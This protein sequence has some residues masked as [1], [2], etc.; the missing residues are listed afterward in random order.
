MIISVTAAANQYEGDVFAV[1][2]LGVELVQCADLE[3]LVFFRAILA[4]GHNSANST[5]K[6]KLDERRYIARR[7]YTIGLAPQRRDVAGGPAG[8]CHN[9]VAAATD[10]SVQERKQMII[11][12]LYAGA[13]TTG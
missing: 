5:T 12:Q 4:D 1:R 2:V 9:N 10:K 8:V 13:P 11:R 6:W 3:L 7:I